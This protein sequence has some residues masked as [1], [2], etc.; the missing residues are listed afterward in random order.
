[1]GR[2]EARE[3]MGDFCHVC[4]DCDGKGCT[5]EV[6]G[7]GGAG[8]GASF[9]ANYNSL[10]EYKINM[11]VLHDVSQPETSTKILG[12]KIAIPVLAAP[13]GGIKFNVSEN[14][15]EKEYLKSVVQGCNKMGTLACAGDGVPDYVFE[16]DIEVIK[17]EAGDI[18]PF[19]KPWEDN[20][21]SKKLK[22]LK[23]ETKVDTV[24]IDVDA[25]GLSTIETMGKEILP[26]SVSNLMELLNNYS[27]NYII[28]G[29]MTPEDARKAVNAGVD[30]IV[31]SNHGG[32]VLDYTPGVAEVLPAIAKEVGNDITILAD[33]G[34]RSGN[35]VLKMI[36]LGADAVMIGRPISI[37]A[38]GDLK[39]GVAEYL[40]QIRNELK[41][42]MILTGCKDVSSIN[43][44]IL[45]K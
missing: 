25:I 18:I 45:Y 12:K 26:R 11:K 16:T 27:F 39:S 32:R 8:T 15:T 10:R 6:P 31:V 2:K 36:A 33:G 35:D 20:F 5:G 41:K 9:K 23:A 4:D 17:E 19:I 28:K 22:K 37:A 21:L 30:A 13:I 40:K 1:M 14:I 34:I 3:L 43:F 44:D 29:I 38:A 7:M 42:N 24:G